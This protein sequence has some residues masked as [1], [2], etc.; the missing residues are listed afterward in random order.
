M[1]YREAVARILALR[2]GEMA[3]MRPGLER[4]AR[5]QAGLAL[6]ER[7]V[8][9]EGRDP[10]PGAD[11][12][13]VA[14]LGTDAAGAVDLGAVDDL[15]AGLALDPESLGDRHLLLALL[16]GLALAPPEPRHV[17]TSRQRAVELSGR[18]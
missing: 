3:G 10:L 7:A 13:G 1:T 17:P 9:D 8:V 5:A 6:L 2:G 18:R 12:E 11:P 4:I 15:L 14:A 16:A